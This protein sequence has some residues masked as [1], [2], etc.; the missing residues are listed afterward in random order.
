MVAAAGDH[1]LVVFRLRVRV[2]VK[3]MITVRH[4]PQAQ[5]HPPTRNCCSRRTRCIYQSL[6]IPQMATAAGRPMAN[7]DAWSALPMKLRRVVQEYRC[8]SGLPTATAAMV[9][10]N[11]P[12]IPGYFEAAGA[13]GKHSRT[14]PDAP[15]RPRSS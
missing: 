13:L 12:W 2:R 14:C 10:V 1:N 15:Q 7:Q 8:L 9:R 3:V 5:P 6:T 11:E 4:C